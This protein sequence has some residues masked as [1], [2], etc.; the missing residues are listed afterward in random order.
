MDYV[1]T[2]AIKRINVD[3]TN[4]I[5]LTIPQEKSHKLLKDASI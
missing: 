3:S 5:L 2:S 4:S 1:D